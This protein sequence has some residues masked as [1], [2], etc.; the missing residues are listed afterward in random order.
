[1]WLK[2]EKVGEGINICNHNQNINS[3]E[4]TGLSPATLVVFCLFFIS[5]VRVCAKTIEVKTEVGWI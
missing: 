2:L 3:L 4:H 1:M 5:I